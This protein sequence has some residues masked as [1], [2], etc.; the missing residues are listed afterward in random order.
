MSMNE[1][2]AQLARHRARREAMT[3]PDG[4]R[5]YGWWKRY[6]VHMSIPEVSQEDIERDAARIARFQ[7]EALN[8][9]D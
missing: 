1:M 5:P 9:N 4:S 2:E 7:N 6:Q 8:A 3:L